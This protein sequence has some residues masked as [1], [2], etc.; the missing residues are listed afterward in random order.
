MVIYTGN[1][2]KEIYADLISNL[3]NLPT[4]DPSPNLQDCL[5]EHYFNNLLKEERF[6]LDFVRAEYLALKHNC[7]TK[8]INGIREMAILQFLYDFH[9]FRALKLL[10]KQF[11]LTPIEIN[12]IV[13]YVEFENEYPCL[14]FSKNTAMAIDEN[15]SPS[16][17]ANYIKP[18]QKLKI[19]AKP[20]LLSIIANWINNLFHRGNQ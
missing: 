8:I 14:S 3:I 6:G 12:N 15:W 9:N 13:Q 7:P 16:W 10:I 11:N 17:H 1:H 5:K 20:S 18:L 2:F 19:L 4:N